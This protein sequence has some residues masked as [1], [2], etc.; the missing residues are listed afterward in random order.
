MTEVHSVQMPASAQ[1]AMERFGFGV[2]PENVLGIQQVILEEV[3][4][5]RASVQT[6]KNKFQQGMPVL[7]GDPVSPFA[8][9]GFNEATDILLAKCQ[10]DID[11]LNEVAAGLADAARAYGKSETEIQASI[12]AAKPKPVTR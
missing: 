6:F 12:T 7:G 8:S 9:K 10:Q 4:R 2:T 11:G 1:A 5:L 3:M